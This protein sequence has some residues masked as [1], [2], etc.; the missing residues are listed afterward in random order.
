MWDF[1]AVVSFGD[2]LGANV[3]SQ[4]IKFTR[5]GCFFGLIWP[6]V[7][8]CNIGCVVFGAVRAHVQ[9]VNLEHDYRQC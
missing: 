9:N 6:Q 3:F 4:F 2:V 8:G 7:I 5:K 1:R